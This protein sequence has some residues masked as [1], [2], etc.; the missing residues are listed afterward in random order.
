[1]KKTKL[2]VKTI[3][4]IGIGAALFFVLARFL[5]IP[6]FADTNLTLQYVVLGFFAVVFGPVAGL[7]IGLLGHIL[8]DLTSGY[9]VWWSWVIGSA[10]V[11]LVSGFILHGVKID[12][13]EFGKKGAVRFILGSLVVHSVAWVGIAPALDVLIYKEPADKVFV[14]GILAAF[15]NFAFT[16]V[17]G[18]ALL[19]GYSKTRTKPG[20]LDQAA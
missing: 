8:T 11:G 18:T 20:S 4:A 7:L 2:D 17:I 6:I 19:F 9:G 13:G 14:Q 1:M 16:A 15:V 5:A 10:F 3:V 12:E